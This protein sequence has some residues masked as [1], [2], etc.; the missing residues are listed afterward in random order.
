[1]R[2]VYGIMVVFLVA[3]MMLAAQSF[4]S[5]WKQVKVAEEK[6]QP[7][8]AL[9]AIEKIERKAEKEQSYGNLLA[10]MLRELTLQNEISPDS[11]KMARK[12]LTD[13][14]QA[15]RNEGKGVEALL[16]DVALSPEKVSVD[17]LI[18]SADSALYR[19]PNMAP[20]YE[21]LI[22]KGEDSQYFDHDLLSMIILAD[23]KGK[24]T[25]DK[26]AKIYGEENKVVAWRRTLEAITAEKDNG[27][28]IALIDQAL[29]E[30]KTW[31]TIGELKNMRNE[32]TCPRYNAE[33]A[34]DIVQ[35]HK[36][37]KQVFRSIRNVKSATITLKSDKGETRT[38]SKA[39]DIKN[40]WDIIDA[41]TLDM[42]K[43]AYGVWTVSIRDD[44]G[45][46]KVENQKIYVT[47]LKV[48]EQRLPQG[49]T[50][51]VVVDGTTGSPVPNATVHYKEISTDAPEKTI[52]TDENGEATL[53]A[54]K[55]ERE[56]YRY[57][58]RATKGEDTAMPESNI[59]TSYS[60]AGK[61]KAVL[62]FTDLFTDRAIYR[63]GQ[64]VYV[65]AI[66]H[67]LYDG[68]EPVTAP[69][70]K[71]TL[72]LK[73]KQGKDVAEKVVVTDEYG[74]AVT[75]FTV[76]EEGLNG[77]YYINAKHD[78]QTARTTIKVEDYKRPTFAV[79]MEHSHKNRVATDGVYH[80]GDTAIVSGVAKTYS[81][82]P[83]VNARVACTVTRNNGWWIARGGEEIK[84]DTLYTD[85]DGR[86]AMEVPMAIPADVDTTWYF[87]YRYIVKAEVT[88]NAGE[89]QSASTSLTIQ[90]NRPTKPAEP[91]KPKMLSASA[92][93]FSADNA[94]VVIMM[95][96]VEQDG[97]N[98]YAY[99][100]LCAGNK[101][102]DKGKIEFADSTTY[103]I[104]YKE[105]YGD[106]IQFSVAWIKNG[107][108]YSDNVKVKKYL[109]S[110]KL[111]M[112]WGTFRDK[113]YPGQ[114]ETWTLRI[115]NPDG[116]PSNAQV[117]AVMYDKSLDALTSFGWML[118]DRRTLY[119]P[120]TGWH[121]NSV[122]SCYFWGSKTLRPIIVK[123]LAFNQ[124][125]AYY[126]F[127]EALF[128]FTRLY[129]TNS[130]AKG[131]KLMYATA[132]REMKSNAAIGSFDAVEESMVVGYAADEADMGEESVNLRSDF[133]ETAFFLPQVM[134]DKNGVA[135]LKFTMPESVTTWR[136]MALAHDKEMRTAL[137]DTTAITQKKIMIQGRM[138][139]FIRV[140]D[141][142]TIGA[143]VANLTEKKQ[144][145]TVTLMVKDGETE[146]K[147]YTEKKI[148]T[149]E[150]GKTSDV[151]FNLQESAKCHI[152][153]S[154]SLL[155]VF[156]AEIPNFSDGEQHMLPVLPNT[157]EEKT[158]TATII[159][160]PRKMMMDALPDLQVP[161]SKNAITLANAY[162]ANVL[163]AHVK[164]TVVSA[165]NDNVL[166]QLLNL[167]NAD[168][169]FS[170]Y[171]GMKSSKYITIEV[172]KTF[173]RLN[174]MCGK[175]SRTEYMMDRAFSYAKV[176][177]E[178]EMCDMKKYGVKYL[179]QT[180]LDWL[181]TLAISEKDGGGAERYFRN[182]I[183]GET[184]GDDMQTKAVAAITLNENG[185]KKKAEEFAES[186]K[187]HTV[188]R[189]DMG[190][191]FDSYRARYSWCDYRIPTHTMCV[192]A[193]KNVTPQDGQTISEML[194][195]LVSAKRTQ[196]WDNPIN[197]VNAIYALYSSKDSTVMAS[198]S[199]KPEDIKGALKVKRAV[200]GEMK[201]GKKV[202]VTLTI[203][204]DRDYDFVTVTDNR[205]ACMDPV[206]QLSGY[207]WNSR[208]GYYAEMRD[209]QSIYHFDQLAKG[210]HVIETEYYIE[211]TGEYQSGNAE[212]VCEYAP[213][214]RGY[215][216]PVI[217]NVR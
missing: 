106:G 1:M 184:K 205:A 166:A 73:D 83:V 13:R 31:K 12:R 155:C 6:D 201:V 157:F 196:R 186:I 164:D 131:G 7:K 199:V 109:P 207:H 89:T 36:N 101:V 163:T 97:K 121:T 115:K 70:E 102:V 177:M 112:E 161:K 20:G 113:M 29:T 187:Q 132:S 176:Q 122:G 211:R 11:L 77:N 152:N 61:A 9:A 151:S 126:K 92:E 167:Q 210:T 47:D 90:N 50:R 41:D 148:V 71:V 51:V 66:C 190:R 5:L 62:S 105:E 43:L 96:N 44:K 40:E 133:S 179:S 57:W 74:T 28:K 203:E 139:R 94:P 197:T 202:K 117:M 67:N 75:E 138:P 23:D 4:T 144:K 63:R 182:M 158:D 173:A 24:T 8:S 213:E 188:Y 174:I 200:S 69:N 34:E 185:K 195:W 95:R 147:L 2:R 159:V 98:T 91:E 81:G 10:A 37:V 53:E 26:L 52:K 137:M 168:G 85:G 54:E 127:E 32:L 42:G 55:G 125:D 93:S 208:W 216:E 15:W 17:S 160:N 30:W 80:L 183:Y 214:F 19:K 189:E 124:I 212:V 16:A 82:V 22:K 150:A 103:T 87:S 110:K 215:A 141:K 134:A 59:W 181:Y 79:T 48:I 146:K 88:D 171:G 45:E 39:F 56:N 204:A 60:Q 72:T 123:P 149:I 86:F 206:N 178:E 100:T 38:Y 154:T 33:V 14:Q 118:N 107:T 35:T 209:S 130:V 65:T 18:A 191:Y 49:K 162:Y 21:P 193:L 114:T 136:F 78:I 64:T 119:T 172:L 217:I 58:V 116:T 170:W 198:Y 3:T 180:A 140:D 142:A 165:A 143:T 25:T 135:T 111:T 192:E 84:R 175:Q 27:K 68:K 108:L 76:P 156:T 99:Y 194:R 129:R 169:G 128:P 145:A 46:I 104:T 153:E 120:Y